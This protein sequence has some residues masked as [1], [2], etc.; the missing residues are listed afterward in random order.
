MVLNI[1]SRTFLSG[2]FMPIG[3][4]MVDEAGIITYAN[5]LAGRLLGFSGDVRGGRAEA[6][7]DYTLYARQ[8]AEKGGQPEGVPLRCLTNPSL[9]AC[10][11]EKG[12]LELINNK[13]ENIKILVRP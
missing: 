3:V 1:S 8:Q 13:D 7:F 9:T 4:L 12:F 6:F 5:A 2:C 11:M 10:A